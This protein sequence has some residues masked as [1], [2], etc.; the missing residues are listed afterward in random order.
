M[1]WQGRRVD[2]H[3]TADVD[4]D[5]VPTLLETVEHYAHMPIE[6]VTMRQLDVATR[7]GPELPENAT[8]ADRA[9]RATA[10]AQEAAASASNMEANSEVRKSESNIGLSESFLRRELAVRLAHRI[11]DFREL[12]FLVTSEPSF[13]KIYQLYL[14]SFCV[15]VGRPVLVE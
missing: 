9:D 14:D 2:G 7:N 15:L 5:F 8:D 11:R 3:V 13:Q 4:E 6:P 10:R 12:P 1:Q